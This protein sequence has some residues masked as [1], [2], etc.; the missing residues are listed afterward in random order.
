ML[1]K[2]KKLQYYTKMNPRE[3]L[4]LSRSLEDI[5]PVLVEQYIPMMWRKR[6]KN[7]L[8]VI[9][10][11]C[12]APFL[13]DEQRTSTN[14]LLCKLAP[15][16]DSPKITVS[17]YAR[18]K[19][20]QLFQVVICILKQHCDKFH[21]QYNNSH[22]RNQ[23]TLDVIDKV[24]SKDVEYSIVL[25]GNHQTVVYLSAES[26]VESIEGILR[27]E[28]LALNLEGTINVVYNSDGQ[29]LQNCSSC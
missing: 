11:N 8:V 1:F 14:V 23:K 7:A 19:I 21:V 5:L 13:S 22:D 26:L 4:L 28:M 2:K 12:F 6:I 27:Q 25:L 17:I 29:A 18:R 9:S 20:Q 10:S 16:L 24:I 15:F 3:L